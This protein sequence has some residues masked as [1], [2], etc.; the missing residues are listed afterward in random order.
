MNLFQYLPLFI[1]EVMRYYSTVP[2]VARQSS[3]DVVIDGKTVPPNVRIDINL[4]ALMHN[5]DI[6]KCPEVFFLEFFR[7]FF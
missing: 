1:K 5:P 7:H 2:L 4:R 6:W 3:E